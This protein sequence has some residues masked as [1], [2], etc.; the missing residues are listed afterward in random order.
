MYRIKIRTQGAILPMRNKNFN[1][2]QRGKRGVWYFRV[3]IPREARSFFGKAE[4][5]ESTRE[6][7]VVQARRY[8]DRRL[9]EFQSQFRAIREGVKAREKPPEGLVS[10]RSVGEAEQA[11]FAED[12]VLSTP[13]LDEI[14]WKIDDLTSRQFDSDNADMSKGGEFD[15][16]KVWVMKNTPEGR[17]LQVQLDAYHGRV[18]YEAEGE[19][20]L[21]L[22]D[23]KPHTKT[24]HRR[25]FKLADESLPNIKTVK[26]A[27]VQQWVN[28]LALTHSKPSIKKYL[29]ALRQLA[30]HLALEPDAFSVE[31]K[32]TVKSKRREVWEADDLKKVMKH[33]HQPYMKDVVEIALYT[34]ARLGAVA[35]VEYVEDKDWL[36]FPAKKSETEDRYVP[37]P[38]ALRE[39]VQR[40]TAKPRKASTIST[41]FGEAKQAAGFPSNR[42]PSATVLRDAHSFRHMTLSRLSDQGVPLHLAERI[43]GHQNQ[44]MAY[45]RYGGK[46]EVEALR[47]YINKLDWSDI[48]ETEQPK[49]SS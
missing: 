49:I 27:D 33:L 16:M 30:K 18:S 42:D 47:E 44:S 21:K 45:G 14:A 15:R 28:K 19:E 7:D 48:F 36:K 32:S 9:K 35:E 1:L 20:Y 2:K 38:D 17:A 34:G 41:A 4:H 40:W 39:T 26:K 22:A 46:G 3:D 43:S 11:A 5:M 12:D 10:L 23:L 24:E 13:L 6:T 25:A 37:C 8:R 29:S 31:V